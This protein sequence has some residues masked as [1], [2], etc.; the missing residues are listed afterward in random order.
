MA[1]APRHL[2]PATWL[3][4]LGSFDLAPAT[5]LG[6]FDD[7]VGVVRRFPTVSST[8]P[9][10]WARAAGSREVVPV[11]CGHGDG[12]SSSRAGNPVGVVRLGSFYRSSG[13]AGASLSLSSLA[14]RVLSPSKLAEDLSAAPRRFPMKSQRRC[15]TSF[16]LLLPVALSAVTVVAGCGGAP[17]AGSGGGGPIADAGGGPVGVGTGDAG[18]LFDDAMVPA[19]PTGPTGPTA[20]GG[21]TGPGSPGGP[22]GPGSPGG[23]GGGTGPGPGGPGQGGGGEGPGGEG[24][25]G[26]AGAGAREEAGAGGQG[27][28]PAREEAPAAGQGA[29]TSQRGASE[30]PAGAPSDRPSGELKASRSA[31]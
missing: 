18:A 12:S 3:G 9:R 22:T 25:G 5:W 8:G 11:R 21:A 29:A 15:A 1:T 13:G 14:L 2:A 7:L 30:P 19:S 26:G 23:S 28:A 6:S 16:G 20:P 4:S 24:P 17:G 31:R 10:R 27:E